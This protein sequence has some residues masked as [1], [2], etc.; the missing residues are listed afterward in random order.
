MRVA[1]ALRRELVSRR[2]SFAFETV[3]SD[4]VGDKL[5]F[6]KEAASSGYT[7]VLCFVGIA[8]PDVSE[9]RVAMRISQGGHAVPSDKLSSRFVRTLA[10]LKSAIR[11]LPHVLVFDNNDLNAADWCTRTNRCP[12]GCGLSSHERVIARGGPGRFLAADA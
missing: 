8:G 9:Q 2:E 1:D 12:S 11:E 4:T 5:T 7:V 6:L 3:F 10:N